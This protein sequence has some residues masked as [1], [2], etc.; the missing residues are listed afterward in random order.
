MN[1]DTIKP[2]K[3]FLISLALALSLCSTSLQAV[4]VFEK[5]TTKVDLLGWFQGGIEAHNLEDGVSIQPT[6]GMARLASRITI[7]QTRGFVQFE[8]SSGTLRLLDAFA[9]VPLTKTLLVTLGQFRVPQTLDVMIR[10]PDMHFAKRPHL[11]RRNMVLG[12]NQGLMVSFEALKD[13]RLETGLT[14]QLAT[15]LF[16]AT[17]AAG[18]LRAR[19][20][21]KHLRFHGAYSILQEANATILA[22]ATMRSGHHF[23]LGLQY[24]DALWWGLAEV[25]LDQTRNDDW[26]NL[27]GAYF[28]LL[29]NLTFPTGRKPYFEAGARYEILNLRNAFEHSLTAALNYHV[30][31]DNLNIGANYQILNA[32]SGWSHAVFLRLQVGTY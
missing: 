6:I 21:L 17:Q 19:Y 1:I 13:L 11:V 28:S 20:D 26:L 5:D 9:E 2:R 10:L 8:G 14:R 24:K 16:D 31:G 15:N 27:N 18:F 22:P 7:E 29:K 32:P 25:H 30:L 4:T 3:H 23:N 12:R